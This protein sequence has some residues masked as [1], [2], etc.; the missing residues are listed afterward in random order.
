MKEESSEEGGGKLEVVIRGLLRVG[1]EETGGRVTETGALLMD[2]GLVPGRDRGL[3]RPMVAGGQLT[4]VATVRG[5]AGLAGGVV[6]SPL[7]S[8]IF[9]ALYFYFSPKYN[10]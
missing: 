6:S 7:S 9:S 3:D 5:G 4:A 10:C 1:R 2:T 8:I